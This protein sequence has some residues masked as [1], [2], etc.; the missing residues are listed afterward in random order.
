M[1]GTGPWRLAVTFV[2]VL[3]PRDGRVRRVEHSTGF[4][5]AAVLGPI[6]QR[7]DSVRSALRAYGTPV[8]IGVDA[9]ELPV[10]CR[11]ARHTRPVHAA[12]VVSTRH[13]KPG[14]PVLR[15]GR[16][17]PVRARNGRQGPKADQDAQFQVHPRETH[18][19]MRRYPPSRD[20]VRFAL[21]ADRTGTPAVDFERS[22][23][24]VDTLLKA[25]GR[26]ATVPQKSARPR[27]EAVRSWTR[28]PFGLGARLGLGN[29]EAGTRRRLVLLGGGRR[30][31]LRHRTGRGSR[32]VDRR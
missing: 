7:H 21:H 26:S 14:G 25:V 20:L 1:A 4:H 18:D 24:D 12:F 6:T 9:L 17:R 15:R 31:G 27:A 8:L 16:C 23:I 3:T 32:G 13:T 19:R 29:R 11:W 2:I 30:G 10:R 22:D 28:R 5:W